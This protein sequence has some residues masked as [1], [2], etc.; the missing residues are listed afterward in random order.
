MLWKANKPPAFSTLTIHPSIPGRASWSYS[1]EILLWRKATVWIIAALELGFVLEACI[2]F[3]CSRHVNI[4]GASLPTHSHTGELHQPQFHY[5]LKSLQGPPKRIL[6]IPYKLYLKS[7]PSNILSTYDKTLPR[8]FHIV[9]Q[10][11]ANSVCISLTGKTAE[12]A[13]LSTLHFLPKPSLF[14]PNLPLSPTSL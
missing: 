10:Q 7:D 11:V 6:H 5:H 2:C 12:F 3:L 13:W 9:Q 8:S 4:S 14:L 1:I